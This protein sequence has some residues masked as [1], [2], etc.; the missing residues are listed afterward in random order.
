M[1]SF[2]LINELQQRLNDELKTWHLEHPNGNRFFRAKPNVII[3]QLPPKTGSMPSNVTTQQRSDSDVPFILIRPL[4]NSF[5]NDEPC[6]QIFNIAIV[7][8]IH[9]SDSYKK[10][11]QG[12]EEVLNLID[13]IALTIKNYQFW[14]KN[15]FYLYDDIKCTYGL[16][17]SIDPYEA[18][19]QAD[20]PYFAAVVMT[21]FIRIINIPKRELNNSF[22]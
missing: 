8:G 5:S 16:P 4:E 10:Y 14:G 2:L 19:L 13:K 9:S 20:A 15:Y 6:Q 21:N 18:G 1:S 11:E 3:G 17:K 22:S 12:V 7:C